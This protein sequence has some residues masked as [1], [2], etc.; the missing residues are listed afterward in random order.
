[1]L[2]LV[3]V[4]LGIDQLAAAVVHRAQHEQMVGGD[5][6]ADPDLEPAV[7]ADPLARLLRSQIDRPGN[8][9]EG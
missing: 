7:D 1:M 5:I 6:G 2:D 4:V 3:P 8:S 9:S